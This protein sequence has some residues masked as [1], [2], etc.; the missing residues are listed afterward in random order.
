MSL[1]W[2]QKFSLLIA[3]TFVGLAI[4][5]L[6]SLSGLAKVSEAYEAQG[7]ARA[8][9][10]AA[11]NLLSDWLTVER[12][13]EDLEPGKIEAYQARLASL[14]QQAA[15]LTT[16]AQRLDSAAVEDSAQLIETGITRYADLRASWLDLTATLGFTASD[17]LKATLSR[18]VDK[19]L[20]EISI[21][22]FNDDI[23]AIASHYR[24]YLDTFEPA[25]ATATREAL[26]R[27]Q[28][29]VKEMDWQEIEIGQAVH[30]F[31]EAFARA[32]AVIQ[33]LTG[34]EQA[35]AELGTQI[36]AQITEQND[37]LQNGL[38][39]TTSQRAE[40]ARA[41]S[42]WLIIATAVAVL[43][44]LL[45][46][47][48]AASRT[49]VRRLD[50]VVGM[51][52]RVAAGDLSGRLRP[53]KNPKDEFNQLGRATNQ[54][55]DDVSAVI[56]QVVEGNQTLATL[57]GELDTLIGQLG[58][59]GEQVEEETEQTATAVQEISHTAVDIA[60]Y[61]QSVNDAAQ[62]ANGAAQSGAE[63]VKRNA[64]SM[65]SLA[66]RIQKTHDQIGQLGKTGEKV[67]SIVDVINGLAEQTNLL[68]L[69]AAIE[70]ARAGEAGRG[71]SV[72]A[73][74]VRSLAEKT[75]SATNGIADIVDA[76]NRETS[77]ITKMMKEGL[78][79]AGEG[80]RSAEEAAMSI[81]RI[82]GSIRQLADDM[83]QVVSSVQGISTTTEEMAQ[84]V[85]QIH[86]HTRETADIRQQLD[87]H[88]ERLSAQTT[89][90]TQASQR[91]RL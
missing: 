61:T 67:N 50:D 79:S 60:R 69:N 55:L 62:H 9:E 63:V 82:T 56:G 26:T 15:G 42:S 73:D 25:S 86:G 21:S 68:A 24:D 57:Q 72:V 36:R 19:D 70:A 48:S 38:I 51:L 28:G 29:V 46:T 47:L 12:L 39:Q 80:E 84:K 40:D 75:V 30:G 85:E 52:T 66:E 78:E 20:R 6:T 37:S 18:Y 8:Y 32:E 33:K 17:G 41:S 11:L 45:L 16:A 27:M 53:S 34:V 7:Q 87:S 35:L 65:S 71:F 49:L 10:A 23:N 74:E 89:T 64:S 22:I 88:I 90:L 58:R 5:T 77:A 1:S 76:L 54:M 83:N 31:A 59:N 14:T 13:S 44:V 2:K 91:F 81:D 3:A 43:V 4:A